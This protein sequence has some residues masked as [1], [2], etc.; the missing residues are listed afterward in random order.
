M[1]EC[2]ADWDTDIFERA[3]RVVLQLRRLGLGRILGKLLR[4]NGLAVGSV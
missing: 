1:M 3:K 2:E 4:G